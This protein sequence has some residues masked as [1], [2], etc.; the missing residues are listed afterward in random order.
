MLVAPSQGRTR[1]VEFRVVEWMTAAAARDRVL[2]VMIPAFNEERTLELILKH[3]LER[4]EVGEV[5][6][7]DDGSTDGTWAI[8]SR[9]AERDSRVR[10]FRQEKNQGKGAALRLALT[11]PRMPFAPVP[12]ADLEYDPR[13]YPTPLQPLVEGRP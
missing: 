3:V 7:V 6:A 10:V 13:D 11:E 4:P 9:C 12:D 2:S 8:M 1:G 5:I